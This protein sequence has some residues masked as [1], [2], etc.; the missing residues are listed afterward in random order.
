MPQ[1][2]VSKEEAKKIITKLEQ[3]YDKKV[4]TLKNDFYENL[5]SFIFNNNLQ[6]EAM[7]KY[8]IKNIDDISELM[9]CVPFLQCAKFSTWMVAE[10]QPVVSINIKRNK[11]SKEIVLFDENGK[12]FLFQYD[13]DKYVLFVNDL[14]IKG[15]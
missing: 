2:I 10:N 11:C 8:K 14:I 12:E 9:L 13:F 5:H 6:K 15:G 7:E 3:E 1:K 4:Q